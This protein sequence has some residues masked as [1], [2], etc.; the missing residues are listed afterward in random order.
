MKH[1]QTILDTL[2]DLSP[3]QQQP[4]RDAMMITSEN[5]W[6]DLVHTNVSEIVDMN[7]TD[8]TWYREDDLSDAGYF[9]ESVIPEMA[10]ADIEGL[11]KALS[12]EKIPQTI[13][14][15]ETLGVLYV[16]GDL[17]KENEALIEAILD[18]DGFDY[19]SVKL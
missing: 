19:S 12:R 14:D 5:D 16:G 7:D 8:D 9:H 18:E 3:E 11:C 1:M 17:T 13:I 4:F 15:I 2:K 10:V 6:H